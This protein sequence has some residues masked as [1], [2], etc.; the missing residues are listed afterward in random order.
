LSEE[1]SMDTATYRVVPVRVGEATINMEVRELGGPS[2]VSV[3]DA[4]PFSDI[5][6]AL[7]AMGR[8]LAGALAKVSPQ[9]A[10]V[11]L[12]L[13]VGLAAGKLVA[14]IANGSAKAN[15]K[16]TLEWAPETSKKA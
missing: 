12:G 5:T 8:E 11:E 13:E 2:K 3:L 14:L 6:H 15:L 9:K 4:L 7:E 10:K 1:V 16:V